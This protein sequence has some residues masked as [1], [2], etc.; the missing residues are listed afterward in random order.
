MKRIIN[1]FRGW[2]EFT[3]AG[4]FPER[5]FNLC[6]QLGVAFWGLVRV[7]AHTLTLRVAA[8]DRKAGWQPATERPFVRRWKRHSVP[9]WTNR[10]GACP[11]LLGAFANDMRFWQGSPVLSWQSLCF[12]SLF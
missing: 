2:V 9:F 12:P 4:A 5:L 11:F 6:A 1:F 3:V 8:S 10:E 7:D